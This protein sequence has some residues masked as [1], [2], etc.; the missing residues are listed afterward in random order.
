MKKIGLISDTHVPERSKTL[1]LKVHELFK[2]VDLIIHS[3]DITHEDVLIELETIAPVE[4]VLGNM[5]GYYIKRDLPEKKVIEVEKVKIGIIH[6]SGSPFGIEE[7][8]AQEFQNVDV[9]VYGHT[10]RAVIKEI[11][12][13]LFINPG[14]PSDRIFS[15]RFTLGFLHVENGKIVKAYIKEI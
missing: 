12:G 11:N 6:G 1:P 8:I 14:T 13:I 10:H 5:D 9:I 7:R 4:A 2:G 3:G 15:S